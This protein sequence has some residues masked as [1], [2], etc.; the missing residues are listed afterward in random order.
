MTYVPHAELARWRYV[1][2]QSDCL[3]TGERE[4]DG[5]YGSQSYAVHVPPA[6]A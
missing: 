5:G 4:C 2:L 1:R 6:V 3:Q